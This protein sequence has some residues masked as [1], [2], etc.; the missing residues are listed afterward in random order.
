M[1][2]RTKVESDHR[3]VMIDTRN[4]QSAI[5]FTSK[6]LF[7]LILFCLYFYGYV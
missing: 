5:I 3:A 2:V 4:T 6:H 7:V 1:F